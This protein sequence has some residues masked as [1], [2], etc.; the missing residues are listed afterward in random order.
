VSSVNG[1]RPPGNRMVRHGLSTSSSR[2][3]GKPGVNGA[4]AGWH[5]RC[6]FRACGCVKSLAD[7]LGAL[8]R[9]SAAEVMME[10]TK[11]E[12]QTGG[13][14]DSGRGS[15]ANPKTEQI[16]RP[17]REAFPLA[18]A[19]FFASPFSLMN[20]FLNDIDRLASG[21]GFDTV[22]SPRTL[23]SAR[24]GRVAAPAW[25]PPIEVFARNGQ[26]VIVA[27][28]PGIEKDKLNVEV[29]ADRVII[30]GE[31]LEQHEDQ[32]G[33]MYQSERRYGRFARAIE[34]PAGAR[35]DQGNA[36][37]ANGI[38]EIEIPLSAQPSTRRLEVRDANT[39]EHPKPEPQ[40]ANAPSPAT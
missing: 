14:E 17:Q 29:D 2:S 34:L 23:T 18:P 35:P 11:V 30:S 4:F 36:T 28:V 9:N 13:D 7:P 39:S 25:I 1:K 20:A 21:M 5:V 19:S 24:R 40:R 10:N 33:S 16:A 6:W 26:L 22:P 37:F 3:R 15:D 12:Q 31:R 8:G 38:L 27:E 32:H